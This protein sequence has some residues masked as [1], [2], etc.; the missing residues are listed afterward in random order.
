M[1]DV[2]GLGK[3]E[4]EDVNMGEKK[5]W[6]KGRAGKDTERG[7]RGGRIGKDSKGYRWGWRR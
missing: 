7:E 6:E 2:D 1:S 3:E 5:G 4:R